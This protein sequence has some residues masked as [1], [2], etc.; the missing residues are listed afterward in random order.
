MMFAPSCPRLSRAS[1]SFFQARRGWPGLLYSPETSPTGVRGHDRHI[2][3]A[4][5]R[6]P[7][8]AIHAVE[9]GVDRGSTARVCSVGNAGGSEPARAVPSVR[10]TPG[11]WLQVAGPLGIRWGACGSLSASP[12]D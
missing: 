3:M 11:H 5:I 10:D 7:G 4:W 9:R 12:L 2:M 6:L 8:R 1:T